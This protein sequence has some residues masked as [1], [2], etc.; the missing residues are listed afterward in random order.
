MA[1]QSSS[2]AVARILGESESTAS[3]FAVDEL[4]EYMAASRL[5]FKVVNVISV[6]Y[7]AG[8]FGMP[9]EE[10]EVYAAT[11]GWVASLLP[12]MVKQISIM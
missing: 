1:G 10:A 5:A 3:R 2:G 11:N 8:K 6:A 12:P 4:T 7:D 9:K